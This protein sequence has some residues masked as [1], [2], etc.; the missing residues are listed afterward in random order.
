M[1]N[2][3]A[4]GTFDF[5]KKREVRKCLRTDCDTSFVVIHTDPKKYCS[6]SCAAATVNVGRKLSLAT[7]LKISHTLTRRGYDGYVHPSKG[8]IKVP[9]IERIC[10]NAACGKRMVIERWKKTKYC[11]NKCQMKVVGGQPTSPKA[12]KGKNGIREDISPVINFY[13]R[14]EANIA[15]L[16]TYLGVKW[17]YAPVTFDI[18]GQKYT[19]D[20]YLPEKEIYVEVKNF[21]W[22]YSRMRDQK[23]RKRYPHIQ[24]EVILKEQ[25]LR[26][27]QRYAEK[28]PEWEYKNGKL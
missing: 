17:E 16:Y 24:L 15:R 7:R 10:G 5:L 2:K 12:S 28:I 27:E 19:P 8:S 3:W 6:S 20:F 4:A 22:E 9:R 11:S 26:Y 13:S 18:G 25:Y 14:W 1:R 23:F 21:W